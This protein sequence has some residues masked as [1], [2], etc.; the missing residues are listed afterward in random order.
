MSENPER[1]S[2]MRAVNVIVWPLAEV[3]TVVGVNE[4]DTS[5]GGVVSPAARARVGRN[6][7]RDEHKDP[8]Q[9]DATGIHSLSLS[10]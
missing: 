3:S 4:K 5:V 7:E 10:D 6:C 9:R 2:V 8:E 1:S